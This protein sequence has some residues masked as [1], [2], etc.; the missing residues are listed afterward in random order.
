MTFKTMREIFAE[1]DAK[2]ESERPQPI[3]VRVEVRGFTR[4]H[5][6]DD[7]CKARS[8]WDNAHKYGM[9]IDARP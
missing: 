8:F 6:F 4:I 3:T 7:I 5:T 2:I 9:N 1:I